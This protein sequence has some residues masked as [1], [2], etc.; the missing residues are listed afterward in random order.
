MRSGTHDFASD[1]RSWRR[2]GPAWAHREKTPFGHDLP[3]CTGQ[4]GRLLASGLFRIERRDAALW[5]PLS[6]MR[7]VLRSA[8]LFER[9][10]RRMA[11]GLA[12]LT[13]TEAVKDVDAVMPRPPE[14]AQSVRADSVRG[15][16][17][18]FVRAEEEVGG[19]PGL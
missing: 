14:V 15:S 7:V 6:R 1:C 8:P 18:R 17:A 13:L 5:M 3:Y 4:L 9:A 2:T 16:D 19:G 11:P 12:G 10:G